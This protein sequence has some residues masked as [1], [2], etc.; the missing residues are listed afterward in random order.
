MFLF[1]CFLSGVHRWPTDACR[2]EHGYGRRTRERDQTD[3]AV[4]LRS[5]WDFPGLGYNG[6]G[7]G[8]WSNPDTVIQNST[9]DFSKHN[10][11]LYSS[12]H[13]RDT[14]Q[15]TLEQLQQKKLDLTRCFTKAYREHKNTEKLNIRWR[16]KPTSWQKYTIHRMRVYT[17]HKS[18]P[19]SLK[20][21]E[22]P[23][24]QWTQTH[25]YIL[26]LNVIF[27]STRLESKENR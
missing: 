18:T 20:Q 5:Q 13:T 9:M 6:S 23:S 8:T 26:T 21:T 19:G 27:L 15:I 24:P 1:F 12:F 17:I 25:Q 11:Y 14:S 3:C 4:H 7:A 16:I 2:A 22:P 10:F